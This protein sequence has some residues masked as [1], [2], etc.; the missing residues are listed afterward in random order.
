MNY[1]EKTLGQWA[2]NTQPSED[3]HNG[4]SSYETWL[5]NVYDDGSMLDEYTQQAWKNV[6]DNYLSYES[7][8]A[9]AQELLSR[10]ADYA[11]ELITEEFAIDEESNGL[12][13]DLLNGTIEKINWREIASHY[14]DDL[15]PRELPLWDRMEITHAVHTRWKEQAPDEPPNDTEWFENE[16]EAI[17]Y[18]ELI[19]GI[20][21]SDQY[22][23]SDTPNDPNIIHNS[24]VN[25]VHPKRYEVTW[26]DKGA[27][28]AVWLE[29]VQPGSYLDET[30]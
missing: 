29:E 24:I 3:Q 25:Q 26:G 15:A 16:K 4:W 6:R 19:K 27:G 20:A 13:K 5:F 12:K 22:R 21:I 30:Y 8:Q 18:F 2:T 28:Y 23:I 1:I 7:E 9:A 17:K 11:K 14:I 10:V